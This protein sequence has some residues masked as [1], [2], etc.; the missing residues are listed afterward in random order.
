ME[1]LVYKKKCL[2][3]QID[4]FLDEVHMLCKISNKITYRVY[5]RNEIFFKNPVQK[6]LFWVWISS[7]SMIREIER[8]AL[9]FGDGQFVLLLLK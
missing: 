6:I 5:L 7:S 2:C 8:I 9:I 3:I 4:N 1:R